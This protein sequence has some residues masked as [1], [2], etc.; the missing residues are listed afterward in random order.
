MPS[1]AIDMNGEL[2]MNHIDR[3]IET[4]RKAIDGD[5]SC[6]VDISGKDDDIDRLWQ[7]PSTD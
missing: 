4:V 5:F 3:I 7:M 1:L 2:K 6:R